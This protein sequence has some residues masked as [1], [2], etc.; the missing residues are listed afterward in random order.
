MIGCLQEQLGNMIG[1]IGTSHRS[2]RFGHLL[3]A[4][5]IVHQW[6]QLSNKA[7]GI[8]LIIDDDEGAARFDQLFSVGPLGPPRG[9]RQGHQDRWYAGN[10]QFGHGRG[11]G[12]GDGQIGGNQELG[13][14]GF[15]FDGLV[16]QI[17]GGDS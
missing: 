12:S 6:S 15:V 9:D 3:A 1:C 17:A 8:E 4:L 16:D 10:G 7:L 14:L 13:H 11:A 2:G 5:S